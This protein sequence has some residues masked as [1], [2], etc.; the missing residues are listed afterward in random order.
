MWAMQGLSG[1]P[2]VVTHGKNKLMKIKLV[3]EEEQLWESFA[4]IWNSEVRIQFV[5]G[6]TSEAGELEI[7]TASAQYLT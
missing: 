5:D 6:K 3:C 4:V 7:D 2:A 1:N